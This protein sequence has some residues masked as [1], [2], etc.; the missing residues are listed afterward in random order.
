[1]SVISVVASDLDCTFESGSLC[2]YKTN[3][4]YNW[5]VMRGDSRRRSSYGNVRHPHWIIYSNRFG[6]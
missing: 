1:M 3:V 6:Q 4:G 5:T 2:S